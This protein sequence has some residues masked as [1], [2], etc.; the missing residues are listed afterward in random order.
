MNPQS[1]SKN[2]NIKQLNTTIEPNKNIQKG[3]LKLPIYFNKEIRN[4]S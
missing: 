1:K 2:M 3:F 4:K